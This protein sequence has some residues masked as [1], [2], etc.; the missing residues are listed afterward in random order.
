MS[1]SGP[2]PP[3]ALLA[4]YEQIAPGAAQQIIA[5]AEREQAFAHKITE[6][7]LDTEGA[8][9]KRGQI[10]AVVVSLGAFATAVGLAFFGAYTA[11]AVVGG[12]TVVSLVTAFI[13]GR[14]GGGD[15]PEPEE[16]P[17]PPKQNPSDPSSKKKQAKKGGRR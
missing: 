5:M 12:S 14:L 9:S 2:L 8:E 11:A 10:C 7:A 1:F 3:P 16:K 17:K 13:V 4:Q 6:K 15:K